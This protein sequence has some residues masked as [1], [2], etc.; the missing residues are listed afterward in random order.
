MKAMQI[1]IVVCAV[2]V[3]GGAAFAQ[4]SAPPTI[5]FN[6][7]IQCQ[8]LHQNVLEVRAAG[9]CY[10]Q[11]GVP[12]VQTGHSPVMVP[13]ANGNINQTV[14]LTV[15]AIAGKDLANAKTYAVSLELKVEGSAV[16][17]TP[18]VGSSA[19]VELRSKQGTPLVAQVTGNISW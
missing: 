10:D 16:F 8:S 12:V 14:T 4:E 17:T 2:I 7:P 11:S 19:P 9:C 18:G 1:S 5:T 15:Q 3:L 13:D 6:V